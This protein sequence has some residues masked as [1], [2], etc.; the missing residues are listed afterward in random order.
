MSRTALATALA[1]ATLLLS[2]CGAEP[3]PLKALPPEVPADLCS[4]VPQTA[5]AGLETSSDADETGEPTAACSLRTAPGGRPE[6]R[7]V[8]T[9]TKLDDDSSADDVLS[10][11]CRAID[12]TTYR[13]QSGFTAEGADKACAGAGMVGAAGSATLAGVT[14]MEVVT[15]R[16]SSTPGVA[17][18]TLA[19]SKQVLESVLSGLSSGS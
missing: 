12:T 13:V 5:K 19:R 8:V 18:P 9:W 4:L 10:S 14:G 11:Q 2:A 7:G 1:A 15:V 6:V 16:W 17:A 3:Q